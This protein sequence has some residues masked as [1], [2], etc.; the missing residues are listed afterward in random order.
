M[1]SRWQY[2][3]W[4]RA[5]SGSSAMTK[6]FLFFSGVARTLRLGA[7]EAEDPRPLWS[8]GVAVCKLVRWSFVSAG[9]D[10]WR[11]QWRTSPVVNHRRHRRLVAATDCLL[12]RPARRSSQHGRVRPPRDHSPRTG[13]RR[14]G[15]AGCRGGPGKEDFERHSA[16]GRRRSSSL[17]VDA[18]VSRRAVDERSGRERLEGLPSRDDQRHLATDAC[19]SPPKLSKAW[20]RSC[21]SSGLPFHRVWIFFFQTRYRTGFSVLNSFV[22]VVFVIFLLRF[23]LSWQLARF[24]LRALNYRIV[25]YDEG[26]YPLAI[27][28][29]LMITD[30]PGTWAS[31]SQGIVP[32]FYQEYNLE[33]RDSYIWCSLTL[34][35]L[36]SCC[37]VNLCVLL[38]H[39]LIGPLLFSSAGFKLD[40]DLFL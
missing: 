10:V 25:T 1:C 38:S 36:L 24:N 6:S 30:G 12:H 4:H 7:G 32:L 15:A 35:R 23:R 33:T 22:F 18:A 13:A 8:H 2:F 31:G 17:L 26:V 3:N 19:I 34:L 16:R 27:N 40:K 39:Q 11:L 9:E 29:T 28:R 14:G 21:F 20:L 5:S 37:F